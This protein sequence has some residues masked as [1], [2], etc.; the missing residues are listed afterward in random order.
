[1]EAVVGRTY[2]GMEVPGILELLNQLHEVMAPYIAEFDRLYTEAYPAEFAKASISLR[3]T[4][5]GILDPWR[6]DKVRRDATLHLVARH[7]HLVA[8]VF[9]HATEVVAD[10]S[11]RATDNPEVQEMLEQLATPNATRPPLEPPGPAIG[12]LNQL[13]PHPEEWG[14]EG[15]ASPIPPAPDKP[16]ALPGSNSR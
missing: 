9:G 11:K 12:M 14:F 8:R 4:P 5:G 2:D 10:A 7:K 6:R 1:L 16:K 15:N 3:L 13:L